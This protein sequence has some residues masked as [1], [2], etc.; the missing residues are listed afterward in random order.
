MKNSK[1]TILITLIP[2]V[3]TLYF[4]VQ[5]LLPEIYK[6]NDLREQYDETKNTYKETQTNIELLRNNKK[7]INETDEL[8]KQIADF[9][10]QVPSE[11]EDEFFLVDLEK[12]S[13][14]TS[15]KILSLDS[16]KEKEF[17][18]NIS[19]EEKDKSS[20]K[21]KKNTKKENKKKKEKPIPPVNVYEKSFEIKTLG[22]YNQIINFV[23]CLEL[24]QR[25]FIINGI[26]AEISKNDENNPNPKIEL[27]IEGSTF[28]AVNNPNNSESEKTE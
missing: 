15:T 1:K 18:I 7:L 27:T 20:K 9:D 19:S 24:Y 4:A 25:K 23:S 2:A 5:V 10:I 11:F 21:T 13:I 12:F 16:K 8:N 6:Y 17:E 3:L 26:S 28:K 22:H 14:N